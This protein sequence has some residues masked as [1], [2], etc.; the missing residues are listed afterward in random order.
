[1]LVGRKNERYREL[2]KKRATCAYRLG[3]KI[4][5]KDTFAYRLSVCVC[6]YVCMYRLSK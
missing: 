2:R 1:M 5:E 4:R 3:G 6:I